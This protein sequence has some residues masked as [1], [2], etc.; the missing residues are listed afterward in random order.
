M[1]SNNLNFSYIDKRKMTVPVRASR[2]DNSDSIGLL[3]IIRISNSIEKI[4]N[5]FLILDQT[6]KSCFFQYLSRHLS[7]NIGWFQ[8]T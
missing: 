3:K 4:Q 2:V 7:P 6:V 1:N 8:T 5:Y